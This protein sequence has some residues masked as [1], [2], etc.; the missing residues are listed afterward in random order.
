[1]D[2]SAIPVGRAM[3][4]ILG[5]RK[6]YA[7]EEALPHADSL[8]IAMQLSNFLRDVGYD[9]KIGRVYL[10]LEDLTR[11]NVSE[12]DLAE[13]R[14]DRRFK[15]LM[16]FE[17]E[18]AEQFYTQAYAGVTMLATGRWGVMSGLQIYHDILTDIRRINYDV[19]SKRVDP[20]R[21]E[22]VWL[23]LKSW[24]ATII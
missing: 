10:P 20:T 4:Y 15:E 23:V 12:N 14:I 24:L 19:F 9:W 6:P 13:E 1:M 11:F 2:G 22:K 3:T 5:V 16:E 8:S 17:C 18:R 7:L 21:S